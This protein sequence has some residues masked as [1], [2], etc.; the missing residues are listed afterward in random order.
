VDGYLKLLADAGLEV[1]GAEEA[2]DAGDPGPAREP[3]E[4]AADAL[5][6]L[7]RRWPAMSAAE[8]AI[9]GP[10]AAQLR[11]RLDAARARLPRRAAL[12]QGTPQH[13]GE[14]DVDPAAA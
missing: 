14:E 11:R 9:V 13:D 2:L 7:R 5:S 8:R 4:R 6:E 3:L 10:A 12:A 1:G